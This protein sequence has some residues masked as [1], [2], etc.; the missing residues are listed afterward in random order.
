MNPELSKYPGSTHKVETAKHMH[1]KVHTL[2][3]G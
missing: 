2:Y 1:N 3:V